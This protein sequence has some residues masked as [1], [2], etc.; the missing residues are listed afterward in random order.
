MKG[1]KCK[2]TEAVES[3]EIARSLDVEGIVFKVFEY[4]AGEPVILVHCSAS[5][6]RNWHGF[7]RYLGHAYRMICPDLSGYGESAA[8]TNWSMGEN[9]DYKMLLQLLAESKQPCHLVGH[10]YGGAMAFIAAMSLPEKIKTLT[11]L[12][13]VLFNFLKTDQYYRHWDK[14]F[15][16]AERINLKV[17]KNKLNAA[18]RTFVSYWYSPLAW[19]F[20][21]PKQRRRI[22]TAMTK[23][24][25]EFRDME[26]PLP[27]RGEI[28]KLSMPVHLIYGQ[29]TK[30]S[31]KSIIN[32]L[33]EWLPNS[34]V[35]SI[36]CAGH[37]MVLTHSKQTFQLI[38]QG[39]NK[40]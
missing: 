17:K 9:P 1:K 5:S 25:R 14:V 28:D 10:S 12:E 33:S 6:H 16:T 22:S 39:I 8:C 11:L 30:A 23:I 7:D 15:A 26:L 34:T 2:S 18:A 4:G 36:P 37:M 32:R 3:Y 13:P 35:S 38:A 21:S 24:A 19:W 27:Q 29:K 20:M 40:S 31:V